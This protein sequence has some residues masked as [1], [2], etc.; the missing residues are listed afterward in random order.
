MHASVP[1][2]I[3][4]SDKKKGG[5]MEKEPFF[6]LVQHKDIYTHAESK[7]QR[8]FERAPYHQ[9]AP[10]HDD[11]PLARARRAVVHALAP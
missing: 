1:A 2:A 5:K 11:A 10:K 9:R 3:L 4:Q 8:R 7:Y 6:L